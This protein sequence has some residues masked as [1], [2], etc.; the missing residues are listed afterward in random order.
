LA[1]FEQRY[2]VTTD[3]F[4]AEMAA[5][6]LAGGDAEYVEWAGEAKLLEGLKTELGEL[7]NARY[8]LS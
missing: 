1:Q 3:Y 7:E 4:L 8:Q 6:G 5:E 2:K